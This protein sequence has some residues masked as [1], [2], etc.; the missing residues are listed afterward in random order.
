M[1]VDCSTPA[2]TAYMDESLLWIQGED[3]CAPMPEPSDP[4]PADGAVNVPL[5][6]TLDC[7]LHDDQVEFSSC[8]PLHTG[9]AVS[10][11]F[12]TDDDP[13]LVPYWRFPIS[14]VLAPS[15]TYYWRVDHSYGPA[16]ASSPLWSFTT[17]ADP[18]PVTTSTWGKIKALY[19]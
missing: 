10:V 6:A 12:G 2:G 7:V 19:R 15:T 13:P 11:F 5:A 16:N 1:L 8:V 9:R 4:V 17:A 14:M 3:G 18:T